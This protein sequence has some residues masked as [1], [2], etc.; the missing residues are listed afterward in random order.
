MAY[1]SLTE[2]AVK[3]ELSTLMTSQQQ[4]FLSLHDRSLPRHTPTCVAIVHCVLCHHIT[5][6]RPKL[7]MAPLD[8]TIFS[9]YCQL[10]I[11]LAYFS[12]RYP[13]NLGKLHQ[14]TLHIT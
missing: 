2:K 4:V 7:C 1:R 10:G 13:S 9:L 14:N 8:V 6:A 5:I 11:D 12:V 3:M